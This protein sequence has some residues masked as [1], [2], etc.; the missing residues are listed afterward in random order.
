MARSP[1]SCR[2]IEL[3]ETFFDHLAADLPKYVADIVAR[4]KE[5]NQ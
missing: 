2:Q 5:D 4:K 3:D 1:R